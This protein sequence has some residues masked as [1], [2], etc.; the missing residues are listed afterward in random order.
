MITLEVENFMEFPIFINEGPNANTWLWLKNV[1]GSLC[2]G[3]LCSDLD[4]WNKGIAQMI[5][6]NLYLFKRV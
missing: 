3:S 5:S 6:N 4:V 2:N 1:Y